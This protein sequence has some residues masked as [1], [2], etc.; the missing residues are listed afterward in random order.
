MAVTYREMCEADW[1]SV[2]DLVDRMWFVELTQIPNTEVRKLAATIDARLCLKM[3]TYGVVVVD[4]GSGRLVGVIGARGP[5][6]L[7]KR[8][9]G[10]HEVAIAKALDAGDAFG[11][12]ASENLRR[13]EQE[14]RAFLARARNVRTKE[15]D[16]EIT[17][18]LLDPAYQKL[19]IGRELMERAVAWCKSHGSTL[20]CL[21]T[22]DTLD[23]AFYEH[24]GWKRV[25]EHPA[26]VEIFGVKYS[27]T[28]YVY[29]YVL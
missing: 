21:D 24:L 12:E 1:D 10:W 14:M 27:P 15:Y 29:E 3:T 19:G 11:E 16:G 25:V 26:S 5:E 2:A 8:V 22:D 13:F 9:Q 23:F 17:L 20:L 4:E 18:L 6:P 7:A 28:E